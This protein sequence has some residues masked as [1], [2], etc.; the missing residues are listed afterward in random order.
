MDGYRRVSDQHR[1]V[2]PSGKPP[3]VTGSALASCV[4]FAAGSTYFA[5]WAERRRRRVVQRVPGRDADPLRG[6]RDRGVT[7][8]TSWTALLGAGIPE[9]MCREEPGA[10]S[11]RDRCRG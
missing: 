8:L 4:I 2:V 11:H 3:N 1:V 7:N 6:G 10:G 5:A 9:T